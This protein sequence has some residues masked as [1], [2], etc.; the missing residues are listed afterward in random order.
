MKVWGKYQN[1]INLQYQL[2]FSTHDVEQSI[3]LNEHQNLIDY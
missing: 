2:S 1:V 3:L